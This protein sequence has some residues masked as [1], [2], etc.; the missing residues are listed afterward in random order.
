MELTQEYLKS[1]LHY[2]P[3][4]GV[5]TWRALERFRHVPPNPCT[6]VAL[7]KQLP[8]TRYV[9][10]EEFA[11][12]KSAAKGSIPIFMEL[13][14]LCRARWSEI[15]RLK[16]GDITPQGLRVV[17]SKGSEGEYTALTPRLHAATQAALAFNPNAP[18]PISGAWLVHSK[19]GLR[20][21]QNSF[22]TAWGRAMRDWIANGGE[23]FTFHDLKAAG[24]SDMKTQ[25]AGHRSG[26]MHKTYNRK[27]Q[28]VEPP[29]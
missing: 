1:I 12:F 7:N 19:N 15:A 4:T 11:A 17:R 5:F 22:Q 24:Y 27:L 2:D 3:D 26:K 14:Y 29:A 18:V 13:A 21:K 20:I 8:R 10:Q 23:R 28:I 9:T 6:G 25:S 16:V